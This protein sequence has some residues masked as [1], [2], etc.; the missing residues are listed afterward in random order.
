LLRLPLL[1]SPAGLLL[2]LCLT[3]PAPVF[4]AD[5]ESVTGGPVTD[6]SPELLSDSVP[7]E[8]AAVFGKLPIAPDGLSDDIR[9]MLD[10]HARTLILREPLADERARRRLLWR[11][12]REVTTL[13]AT[14]GYFS[15]VVEIAG[16]PPA[17]HVQLGQRA[18]IEAVD[19]AFEGDLAG[20]D[21]EREARRGALRQA[22]RLP[23]GEPF[24]QADWSAAKQRLLD[25]LTARDYAAGT[26]ADS[27]AE[28]DPETARVALRVQLDSGP[29]F[30]FGDIEA[31]GLALHDLDLVRRYATLEPGDPYST[32]ALLAFERAL[33]S[34]PYFSSA[35]I[36]ADRDP[37]N[38]A[39]TP[40]R[41]TLAEAS[42]R[43]LSFGAGLS[44]NTGYR[45]E[46]GWS[47]NNLWSRSWM[48]ST[49]LRVDQLRQIA[50]ADVMLPPAEKGYRDS[51]GV[52]GE[53]ADIQDLVTRRVGI[54]AVRARIRG[55]VEIRHSLNLQRE[56]REI[57][58]QEVSTQ[59]SLALNTSWT[60]RRVDDLFD[61]RD[62]WVLNAQIGGGV[63]G[64]LSDA[65]FLRGYAKAQWFIPVGLRD[66]I[67]LRGEAGLTGGATGSLPQDFLFR[68]GGATSVRGYDYLQLGVRE[69]NAIVGG[70]VL[71]VASAEYVHWL[72]GQWGAAVFL[73]AGDA[74]DSRKDFNLA[75][76]AGAGVRWRS[77]AG[78][79]AFDIAYGER[80]RTWRPHFSLAIA[81]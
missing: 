20:E 25:D 56:Q 11:V 70:R 37:A 22:W 78:P 53:N 8:P 35:Q 61:P 31:T 72:S 23:P 7:D 38:A 59:Q 3:V 28:V 14:E 24:R 77:P 27:L 79:I 4:A 30:R 64:L 50:F 75:Y 45:A 41:I 51:F 74:T 9:D 19:I 58:G 47:D 5:P 44:S 68:A 43:R 26:L 32:D 10:R 13:L 2:L 6:V 60:W 18:V 65:N 34:S 36:N 55:D 63:K 69:G 54:G 76:G 46:V 39:A 1:R 62:G 33:L 80:E 71:G 67:I 16:D 81:F 73:D 48:L 57:D 21:A 66:Q 40:V 17:L 42:S 49:A 52:L 15:P 29:A 12:S